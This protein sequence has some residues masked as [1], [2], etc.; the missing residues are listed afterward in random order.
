MVML[1]VVKPGSSHLSDGR[2]VAVIKKRGGAR[3]AP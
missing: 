3:T 1:V 2:L